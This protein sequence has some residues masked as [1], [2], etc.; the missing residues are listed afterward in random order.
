MATKGDCVRLLVGW[1]TYI[2]IADAPQAAESLV[3]M[4]GALDVILANLL[5]AGTLDAEKSAYMIAMRINI[6]AAPT[7]DALIALVGSI[8]LEKVET[9]S[10][11]R[12]VLLVQRRDPARFAAALER[13]M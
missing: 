4:K 2:K 9:V 12:I 6:A 3:R 10:L 1:L 7:I 13:P 5:A 8:D 11:K